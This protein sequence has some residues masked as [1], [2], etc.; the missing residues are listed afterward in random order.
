M[1]SARALL[2]YATFPVVFGGAMAAAALMAGAGLSREVV[3]P[4][5]V[6]TVAVIISVLERVHPHV[7]GWNVPRGDVATDATHGLV[8]LLL[9]PE[10]YRA[11]T[12]TALYA[13]GAAISERV[14]SALWPTDWPVLAQLLVALVVTELG[15]YW[16]HR[17]M[18]EVPLLW[19]LHATHHTAARLYWLNSVRFHPLD[20]LFAYSLE[21]LPL[22]LLG[23][24]P[25]VFM[26]FVVFTAIHGMFQH[27]NIRM[28]LGPLNWFFSMAELHRWHHSTLA[29]EGNTNYGTNIILW[30]I[31]FRTR[32][33]P[34]DR[35]PPDSIG[36]ADLPFFPRGYLAQ[37]ASPFRWERT[38]ALSQRPP[39]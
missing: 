39:E 3:V 17:W 27:A 10:L 12:F 2:T 5:V 9:V 18:H 30:D 21:T 15:Q 7:P 1:S 20:T 37:I 23:C 19:R 34:R 4:A 8:S 13:A 32:F 16:A 14:G 35:E 11:A 25:D 33:L 28:R 29:D 36:V 38:R 22:A 31:V 26:L 6:V 24:P